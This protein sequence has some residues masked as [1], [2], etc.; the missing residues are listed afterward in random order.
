MVRGSEGVFFED[1][2]SNPLRIV[3][4]LKLSKKMQLLL[5]DAEGW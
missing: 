5:R 2:H 1:L 3:W 4:T